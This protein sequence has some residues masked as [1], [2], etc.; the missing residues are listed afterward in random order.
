MLIGAPVIWG[1]SFVVMKGAVD[2]FSPATL[3]GVRFGLAALIMLPFF[4]KRIRRNLDRRHLINGLVLGVFYFMGFWVQT[5][6]LTE[7]TPGKNAFLTATYCVMVPFVFWAI[8][9][10][11]PRFINV[12][13]ACLA[14]AGVGL[15]SIDGTFAIGFGDSMTLVSAVF[16]AVQMAYLGHVARGSDI[17][18]LTFLQFAVMGVMG[19]AIG[20]P[21]EA[22]PSLQAVLDPS[23]IAQ[24]AYLVLA[25]SLLCCLL[26]NVG[27]TRVPPAQAS[28]L[29]SLES[30]FGVAFSVAFYGETLT[31]RLV[32]GFILI[33]IAIVANET[34]S[35]KE[36]P[37]IRKRISSS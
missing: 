20:L 34:L 26:Q 1:S 15:V 25:S 35:S 32:A 9:G 7:T 19:L 5:I 23:V 30:V 16:F 27:Q 6:G 28:L 17:F 37:W 2:V 3:I 13:A 21:L 18:T 12:A 10:K 31:L 22:Q 8:A 33:F 11:R 4:F 36:P 24:M 29:L 14:L